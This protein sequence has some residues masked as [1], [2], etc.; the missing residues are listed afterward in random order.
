MTDQPTPEMHDASDE[1]YP[2]PPTE[3]ELRDSVDRPDQRLP[4]YAAV[5]AY[6][7]QLPTEMAYL[8]AVARNAMIWRAVHAALDAT[9]VGRC[10]SSHCVEGDHIID[11]DAATPPQ[12]GPHAPQDGPQHPDAGA[13]APDGAGGAQAG[14]DGFKEQRDQYAAAHIRD[15]SALAQIRLHIAAHRQRLKLADPVLLA[16]VDAVL[17]EV[18]E[19]EAA[20]GGEGA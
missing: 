8:N 6:I 17:R 13:E 14:A 18:G 19:L 12:D 20:G 3:E 7:A 11:L 1:G 4:A 10:I 15:Q 5:F 2:V 9:P 16:K